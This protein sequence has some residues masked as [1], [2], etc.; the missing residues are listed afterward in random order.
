MMQVVGLANTPT[1]IITDAYSATGNAYALWAGRAARGTAAAPTASQAGDVLARY[2]GN[3]Y[4]ATGYAPLGVARMD[5]V[6]AENYSD[7]TK[8][9]LIQFAATTPGTNTI[10]A[11][12]VT[13]SSS[14]LTVN[15][16]ASLIANTVTIGNSATISGNTVPSQYVGTWT[17]SFAFATTQGTQTYTQQIGNYIKT[18]REVFATFSVITS[19]DTGSGNFSLNLTGL[20]TPASVGGSAGSLI[21]TFNSI[22]GN[23]AYMS[24]N[25]ASGATSVP[26][27]GGAI[28]IGTPQAGTVTYRQLIESDLG[29]AAT[30]SGTIQY[31]SAS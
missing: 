13:I 30:I 2:S 15:T 7:T 23:F 10:V 18:G 9:S 21:I 25:V 8:G 17:P 6:A 16:N 3:G 31:I 29:A 28:T 11:N 14:A 1:R 19:A 12:V 26:V 20:P 24:G 27:Y 5:I 22:A 4:G